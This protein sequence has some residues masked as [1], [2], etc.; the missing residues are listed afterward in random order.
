MKQII[1]PL[2][3]AMMILPLVSADVI[4]PG[5]HQMGITNK[6]TNIHDFPDYVFL[7]VGSLGEIQTSMCPV[8]IVENGNIDSYYKFCSVSVYA[9]KKSDFNEQ[10]IMSMNESQAQDYFN[11]SNVQLVIQDISTSSSVKI[12]S[13]VKGI[14]NYYNID[15]NSVKNTPDKTVTEKSYLTYVY[16]GVPILALL[17]VIFIL[18]KRRRKK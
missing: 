1:I 12:S 3:I 2:L 13:S 18:I 5:Y 15:L 16:I 10:E 9:I 17:I 11:S 7:S 6:I 14:T 4:I 8:K